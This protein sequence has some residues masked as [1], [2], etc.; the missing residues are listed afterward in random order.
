MAAKE[1]VFAAKLKEMEQEYGNLMARVR[2]LQELEPEQISQELERIQ[3]EYRRREQQL[4][5][6]AL[7]CRSKAVSALA[8]T[9]LEYGSR[10]KALLQTELPACMHGKPP[11]E[12]SDQAERTALYAEYAIDFATQSMYQAL[13]AAMNA[14][15]LFRQVEQQNGEEK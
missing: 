10:M 2:L 12:L 4:E 3:M 14:I 15:L 6:S 5:Q 7:S 8:S 13:I 1:M 9:Q 11:T